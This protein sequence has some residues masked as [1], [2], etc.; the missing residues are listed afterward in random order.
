MVMDRAYGKP[1]QI[2]HHVIEEPYVMPDEEKE[3]I[4]NLF[5]DIL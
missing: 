1:K 5:K 4:K 2:S 3:R